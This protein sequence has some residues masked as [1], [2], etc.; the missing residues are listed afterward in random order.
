MQFSGNFEELPPPLEVLHWQ[1]WE[2]NPLE[3]PALPVATAGVAG[4]GFPSKVLFG[5]QP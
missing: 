3:P 1:D 5:V 4:A 2:Q